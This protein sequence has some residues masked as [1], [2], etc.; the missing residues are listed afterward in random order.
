[1]SANSTLQQAKKHRT[2]ETE[3]VSSLQRFGGLVI[4]GIVLIAYT[5]QTE[6]AQEVQRSYEKPYFLLYL[7]HSGYIVL[8]PLHLI[9]LKIALKTPSIWDLLSQLRLTIVYQLIL[10]D[11]LH[12]V[13]TQ[14]ELGSAERKREFQDLLFSISLNNK[15]FYFRFLKKC[16][17][18]TI[19]IAVPSICWYSAVPLTDMT[20]ITSIFNTNAFFAYVLAVCFLKTERFQAKNT[21][22]VIFAI[23]GV[24][25]VSFNSHS[26]SGEGQIAKKNGKFRI[27]GVGLAFLASLS[28]GAYEVWYKS[29]IALPTASS[30]T[31]QLGLNPSASAGEL[32]VDELLDSEGETDVEDGNESFCFPNSTGS[33]IKFPYIPP[34]IVLLHA[35]LVTNLIGIF[36]I[37]LL[38]IPI[39][40]IHWLKWEIFEL[41]P[42]STVTAMI[43]GVILMGIVFHWEIFAP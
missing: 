13:N 3:K 9:V 37:T 25:M 22:A 28:F 2:T 15:I 31:E 24:M 12:S 33:G 41:P 42:N 40:L 23:L 14:L 8:F 30:V 7:T 29:Q 27:A 20:S 11:H 36:T 18:L 34:R 21:V 5:I 1:M 26:S 43:C 39:P 6:L 32:E 4:F 35:N 10:E 19:F 17:L 38:W 16:L